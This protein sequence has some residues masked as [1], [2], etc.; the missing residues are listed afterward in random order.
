[1]GD[2]SKLIKVILTGLEGSIV[3]KGESY[4]GLMP[5]HSFLKDEDIS[6][7][8]THVRSSFGNDASAVSVE[9]VTKVRNSL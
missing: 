1:M 7:I 2:K 9:E 6:V 4:S 5:Q 3:V 8:L